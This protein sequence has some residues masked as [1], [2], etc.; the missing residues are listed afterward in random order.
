M[1]TYIC[2]IIFPGCN[3][4]RERYFDNGAKQYSVT[5]PCVFTFNPLK[6]RNKFKILHC[7]KFNF[8]PL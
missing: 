4:N 8:D 7:I 5:E 2:D 3:L 1:H 6:S